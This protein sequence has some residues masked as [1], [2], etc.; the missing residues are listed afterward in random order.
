MLIEFII[1]VV[2][3][4][5]FRIYSLYSAYGDSFLS[6]LFNSWKEI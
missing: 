5:L 3:F 6:D 4:F 1:M 2:Y